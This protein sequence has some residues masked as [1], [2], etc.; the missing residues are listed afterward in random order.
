[1]L[2]LHS[3]VSIRG[4]TFHVPM[5]DFSL[6]AAPSRRVLDRLQ[7]LLPRAVFLN[8][9][10]FETGRSFHAYSTTLLTP[11]EWL[12]FMGRLLLVTPKGE[13]HIVDTRWVGHRLIA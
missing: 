6:P 1:E 3:N 4:R 2:A 7:A 13:A 11:G 5:V 8:L 10:F 9:A 12:D